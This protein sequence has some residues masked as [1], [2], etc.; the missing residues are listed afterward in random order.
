MSEIVSA[1]EPSVYADRGIMEKG[2]SGE[3]LTRI[4]LTPP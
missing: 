4:F 1:D 3:L 2:K